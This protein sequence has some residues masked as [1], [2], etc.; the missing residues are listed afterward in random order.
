MFFHRDLPSR[1]IWLSWEFPMNDNINRG[2]RTFTISEYYSSM[3]ILRLVTALLLVVGTT[4]SEH[5][6]CQHN[7]IELEGFSHQGVELLCLFSWKGHEPL[8]HM[9]VWKVALNHSKNILLVHGQ[10]NR[11]VEQDTTFR[12][13]TEL[14]A[15]WFSKRNATLR[16]HGLSPEEEG[17][18]TCHITTMNPFNMEICAEVALTVQPGP[19]PDSRSDENEDGSSLTVGNSNRTENWEE[20]LMLRPRHSSGIRNGPHLLLIVCI[21]A[22]LLRFVH[23][24]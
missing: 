1:G 2:G 15:A 20:E 10:E 11:A 24:L 5:L 3:E 14:Q 23:S 18:Y 8:E 12:G 19:E 21:P 7:R 13:R 9:V 4:G 17:T 6:S 22:S 16:L